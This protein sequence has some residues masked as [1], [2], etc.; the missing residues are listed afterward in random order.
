MS[1]RADRGQQCQYQF[2]LCLHLSLFLMLA[3]ARARTLIYVS[4]EQS[5]L[6]LCLVFSPSVALNDSLFSYHP[7]SEPNRF[8]EAP[9]VTF[10]GHFFFPRS[11]SF[12]RFSRSLFW[13][14]ARVIR[15]SD[16]FDSARSW[17]NSHK[18][19][20]I[21]SHTRVDSSARRRKSGAF[22]IIKRVSL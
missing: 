3:R 7:G 4:H 17:R 10:F 5:R 14:H 13:F 8:C 19:Y 1:R 22:E 2:S 9:A 18:K 11:V 20:S 12:I 15:V 16:S 6:S 21:A